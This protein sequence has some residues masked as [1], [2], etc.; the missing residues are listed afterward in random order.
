VT[1]LDAVRIAKEKQA[2]K[3]KSMNKK[4]LLELFLAGKDKFKRA[5]YLYSNGDNPRAC[6][7]GVIG[8]EAGYDVTNT[9][10]SN[11][12]NFLAEKGAKESVLEKLIDINDSTY[13]EGN[14]DEA[15]IAYLRK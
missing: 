9:T 4:K 6:V 8:Y 5:P 10:T 1:D 7:L 12:I 15:I 3:G 14:V 13:G 11:V 2:I